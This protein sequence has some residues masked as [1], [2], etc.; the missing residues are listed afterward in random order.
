MQIKQNAH[1]AIQD[2]ILTLIT[3]LAA[4][5]IKNI[6]DVLSVMPLIVLR[7]RIISISIIWE[8]AQ[9]VRLGN[10]K[11]KTVL[12]KLVWLIAVQHA[13]KMETV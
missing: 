6:P 11:T 4:N 12:A 5:A 3:K 2:I 1:N 10:T 13:N 9:I 8:N 7:V